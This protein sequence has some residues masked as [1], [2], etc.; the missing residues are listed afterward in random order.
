MPSRQQWR[1]RKKH[2]PEASAQMQRKWGE[3]VPGTGAT[4][5]RSHG[6]ADVHTAGLQAGGYFLKDTSCGRPTL[7]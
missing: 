7:Q 2:K 3:S 5:G 6:G 1:E 4:H